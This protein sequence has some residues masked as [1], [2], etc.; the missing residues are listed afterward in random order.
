MVENNSLPNIV[1]FVPDEMRGDTIS[2]GG[3]GNKIIK[4]PNIDQLAKEGAA[5]TKCFTVNP[6]CV[7]SR[8]CIFTGQYIHSNGHRSLYQLLQP[9]EENLFKFLKNKG[10]EV[11]WIG[12]ND[13][14]DKDTISLSVNE[15]VTYKDLFDKKP[16]YKMN[17][18]SEDHPLRKS[19]YYGERTQEEANDI[20][21]YT[22]QKALEY[23][24]SNLKTPFCLYIA[25][26]FPH[27]PYTV[28]KPYFS[29]YNR[30]NIPSPIP[31]KHDD[32]PEFMRLM[33]K[34]YGLDKLTKEDYKE[35]IATYYGMVSKV[36]IQFGQII[37]KLKQI[38]EYDNSAIFFFADHGD[39]MGDYGLTEKWPNAFQDCLI[40]IPLI[41]KI[42]G[43]K[44]KNNI[45]DNLVS[46]ID[47]FPT[48]M[49]IARI[50]SQYTH[51]GKSLIPLL[52]N[53]VSVH[54]EAIFAEGGYNP[55]EPQCF[56]LSV[57]SPN[58]PFL[59][60]YYD[61]TNIP[62]EN[63]STVAR[64][65]MI[66]TKRWKLVIRDKGK[67][68]LYDLIDDSNELINLIDNSE[69]NKVN[70]DLKEH[71]LRWYLRTSDNADWKRKRLT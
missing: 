41:I 37:T 53:E 36:D 28:E 30:D 46:S 15:S 35:I 47:I 34:R 1:I 20:D 27:P 50:E 42:P 54:R 49:D 24:D 8:C 7:P 32:K 56:E 67:E 69:Y 57:K 55:R 13:L 10:Y 62:K 4:T 16:R 5:F 31:P 58:T 17:P 45:Y 3:K 65:A 66:R 63:R 52:Q 51:Y 39:F 26:A 33:Y 19:F 23:L 60:I 43:I 68:E 6:V 40:N 14:F 25:I 29:M 59:G 48:V 2:L 11:I 44:N 9:Y 70:I 12:R 38:G 64:S 61:K 22:I 18:F 71:L 21:Y